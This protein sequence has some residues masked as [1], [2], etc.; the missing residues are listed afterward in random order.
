MNWLTGG[1][2]ASLS[3]PRSL[4]DVKKHFWPTA[5]SYAKHIASIEIASEE[6]VLVMMPDNKLV[7]MTKGE[8]DSMDHSDAAL[9]VAWRNATE[10]KEAA[11][12]WA[13]KSET[14]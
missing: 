4:E 6:N 12:Y 5:E 9:E 3:S 1:R 14:E 2:F 13:Y 11:H 8:L 7:Q 10:R